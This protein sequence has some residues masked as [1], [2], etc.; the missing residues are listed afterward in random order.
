MEVVPHDAGADA[1]AAM[2]ALADRHDLRRRA[3]ASCRECLRSA[4]A[5]GDLA[6]LAPE[7]IQA[8]FER[9]AL[10]FD[11]G[12]LSH[13]FVETRFGLYVADPVAGW[14]RGLR[15][16]GHYRLITRLDGTDEDDYLVLDQQRHA[17]PSAA[18]DGGAR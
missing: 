6:G 16:V 12:V 14:F 7:D 8:V 11:H 5:E 13:P 15:P 9:V 3:E 18:A 17:E 10:V 4:A 1:V 2:R